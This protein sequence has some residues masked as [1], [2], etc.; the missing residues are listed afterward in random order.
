MVH[1]FPTFFHNVKF[2]RET[3]L[4]GATLFLD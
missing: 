4:E 1:K 2:T 3:A